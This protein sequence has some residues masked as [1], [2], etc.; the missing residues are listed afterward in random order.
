MKKVFE[1]VK[2]DK[3]IIIGYSA[4]MILLL[5]TYIVTLVANSN[6]KQRTVMVDH[7]VNVI[8]NLELLLSTIKDAETGARGYLLTRDISFL[9]PFVN[10]KEKADSLQKYLVVLTKDN[11][12]Q[13]DRLTKLKAFT[14]E[15]FNM[16]R[17]AIDYY[18]NGSPDSTFKVTEAQYKSKQLMDRIRLIVSI[19]QNEERHLLVERDNQLKL[20]FASIKTITITS[21]LLTLLLVAIGF[22]TYTWENKGRRTA[23]QNITEYQQ[24][25][26]KRIDEL[27]TA[28]TQLVQ[29]R[30]MEKFTATGRIARTIAHEVRN[31]LT[32]IN[33]AASQLKTDITDIDENSLSLFDIIERNGNRI[34]KLISDLLNTTKFSELN[35][36]N[37]SVN[38][39]LDE[40]LIM[41][42]DRIGLHQVTI[43]KNYGAT[44]HI[45]V[46]TEKIKVAF[47]NII[48]NAIEAM[49]PG[50]GILHV[51]T[52]TEKGKCFVT[53]TD[54]GTG[55]DENALSKLFEPYFTNKPNGNGLGLAN[56]QN[57]IF[58][59]KGTVHVSSIIGKGTIFNI[60][61][62]T[63]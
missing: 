24:Q 58:N 60:A 25:L 32:N 51:D 4:S 50:K 47:L 17:E 52:K 54:N 30:S 55:M 3:R 59:H 33:L 42:Q 39:V 21:L 56:T 28:N 35:F 14:K 53:I 57:I 1:K 8:F 20:S 63:V 9:D 38:D 49:E 11:M 2:A 6:L 13:Q 10:S 44:C 40:A 48:I 16:L 27:N 46:D 37:V 18:K 5:I 12:V 22:V 45:I 36:T 31:P 7:T 43:E 34:N 61:L 23:M 62:D 19:M 26:S 29:M 15:R 41:A